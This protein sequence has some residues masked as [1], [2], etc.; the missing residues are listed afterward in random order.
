MI[1]LVIGFSRRQIQIKNVLVIRPR[2]TK[3]KYRQPIRRAHWTHV[4]F[5]KQIGREYLFVP[6]NQMRSRLRSDLPTGRI[7]WKRRS[8]QLAIANIDTAPTLH[9]PFD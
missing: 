4:E 2:C 5:N 3:E 8:T 7:E 1:I 9:D 6:D